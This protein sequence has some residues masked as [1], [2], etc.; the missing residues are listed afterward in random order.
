[1]LPRYFPLGNDMLEGMLLRSMQQQQDTPEGQQQQSSVAM[2][3]IPKTQELEQVVE[4]LGNSSHSKDLADNI[5]ML[6]L[7]LE[8]HAGDD[9]LV[10]AEFVKC[11]SRV[12][13]GFC[14][15]PPGAH[16]LALKTCYVCHRVYYPA[17]SLPGFSISLSTNNRS[18]SSNAVGYQE[19]LL[20]LRKLTGVNWAFRQGGGLQLC[21]SAERYRCLGHRLAD[22]C[23]ICT[24]F[25]CA[26]A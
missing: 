19:L 11:Y 21:F 9:W 24:F 3:P 25:Q 13:T 23:W 5:S 16:F 17:P 20:E 10:N 4:T 15:A 8:G 18:R 1:M 6:Q 22:M 7:Q 12:L 26:A 14:R 2:L